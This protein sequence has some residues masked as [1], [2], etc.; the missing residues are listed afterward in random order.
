MKIRTQFIITIILFGMI[1]V[2]FAVSTIVTSQRIGKTSQQ[3]NLASNIAQGASELSYLSN[4]YLI[5]GESQ[6]LK[7]WQ[8]RFDSL[9]SLVASFNVDKQEQQVLV[10]N[11]QA[12]TQRLKEVFDSVVSVIRNSPKAQNVGL[13]PAFIQVSWSRMAVQSQALVSDASRLSKLLHQ[14]RDQLRNERTTLMYAMVCLLG[15]FLLASYMLTYR[16]IL[17]SIMTLQA[18]TAVIGSGNLDFTIEEKRNDEIGDLSRAFNKMTTDLKAV[19]ASKADLERE[20]VDRKRAEEHLRQQREWLRV[21]LSSIGDAVIATDTTGQITFLNPVA[22][23]LTGWQLEETLGQPIQT[24]FRIINEKTHQ[25]AEDL[26]ARVLNEKRVIG[27]A[28]DTALVTK[29]GLEVPIEDSAAPILDAT[30]NVTGAVLVFHDVTVKRRAQAA[31]REAHDRAVWLA[32]FPEQNP[33]PVVRASGDGTVLYCNPASARLHGWTCEVGRVLQNELLPLVDRAIAEGK[34]VQQDLELG[35]RSYLV[36][37]VPFPEERYATV[38]G[39]DI[40]ERKKAE[41]ALHESE[42]RYRNLF[43]TMDEGFCIIEMILDVAGRPAD[44]RF[45]EVNPAFERQTGLYDTKDK[46]M[47]D[48]APDHEAHWFEIYGKI[49]LTGEPLHF[50]NEARALNRWYEVYA[51]RVGK[52]EERQVAIIF[53]DI[54]GFKRA[55]EALRESEG[56]LNRAQEIAHLGGW[57]LDLVNNRLTWSNEVYRIFGLQPQE[58]GATYEAFLEAVHPDDRAAVNAAYSGSVGERRDNYEIEHR[59]VRKSTGEIRLV[60]ERCEHVRDESGQII[61][62]IGMVQD[63]TERKRM[64]EELRQSGEKSRLLIKYAPSMLYEIDFRGPAFKSVNDLMCEFLG[65]TREE[66]LAMNPF[67]LLDDEGKALFQ[68][69]IRRKFAGED[70]SDS[71]EY[72]SKTKDGREVYGVLNISFTYKDG[73]PEGAVVV[74]HDITERKRAEEALKQRSSE[75]QKLAETLE[76]RVHERTEEL[77]EAN[78]ALRQLS[79]RL[80]AA[81]EEERK[82]VAGEIH[83]SMGSCLSAIKFKVESAIGEIAKTPKA[84][85]Q[86]LDSIAPAIQEAIEECRRIQMDLRP[87]MLDDLGLLPTLSWFFRRFQTIY[88]TIHIEQELTIEERELPNSLKTV[89]YRIIQEAMNNAAKHS[90]ADLIRISLRKVHNKMELSLKDN[91]C[92]FNVQQHLSLGDSRR[93]LGLTSMRERT[94]L[95]GGSFA[96]ESAEGKGT[97]IRASWPI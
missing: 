49:A 59:V 82:R 88:S 26:V 3:E 76:Q 57:E 44:Y 30:G 31:L 69:R 50:T 32:Q 86:S 75:L 66:L 8:S 81:Q 79:I 9:S 70:I 89:M 72:K 83:D 47:R 40:T 58:F 29:D 95:S 28:N 46:L 92:G 5:Y 6:Q 41:E 22:V 25:P 52:P 10:R 67:D 42:E 7:R 14:V 27:L 12:N 63:I 94:E 18:S 45:L 16:R 60:H 17:K 20:I 73:K 56:R 4:D 43:N 37:V 68:E 54:S 39:R 91:G 87:S 78:R 96:L 80:L 21:T 24:V 85:T 48:L 1:L 35:E 2:I 34:E 15:G 23:T 90:K 36:W 19:T 77:E 93:G 84:A 11:I 51:Y 62:S 33:N 64:E 65:Y 61:G 71:V 74:A 38:Y 13:D 55:E 97:M 53:N